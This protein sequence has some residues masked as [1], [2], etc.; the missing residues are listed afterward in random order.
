MDSGYAPVPIQYNPLQKN[1][2]SRNWKWFVPLLVL[3]CV[4]AVGG[5]IAAV[6]GLIKSSEPY[7]HAVELVTHDPQ[8]AAML[9]APIQTGWLVTGS[10]HLENDSGTADLVIPVKG[11][12]HNGSVYVLAHK[13]AGRWSYERITLAR[14]DQQADIDL[15]HHERVPATEH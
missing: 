11:R 9:G 4:A 1:W 3:V 5:F 8:V 15:L 12:L 6:F 10:I 7:Q 2:F 14:D 13:L